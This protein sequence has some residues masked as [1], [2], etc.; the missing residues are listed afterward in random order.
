[1]LI[2]VGNRIII[3]HGHFKFFRRHL[4]SINELVLSMK[5]IQKISDETKLQRIV[6]CLD[7]DHDGAVDIEDALKVRNISF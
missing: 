2:K 3:S 1:M 4:I 5:R 7:E 6:E